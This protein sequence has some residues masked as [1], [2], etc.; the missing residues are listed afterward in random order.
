MV[1]DLDYVY[2]VAVEEL[3]MVYPNNNQII[4]FE[5]VEESYVRQYADI[6][7]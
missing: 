1:Y 7:D 5:K 4:T 2:R 6:P 3:G